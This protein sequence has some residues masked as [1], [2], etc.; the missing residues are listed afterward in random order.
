MKSILRYSLVCALSWSAGSGALAQDG[1]ERY[2]VILDKQIFGEPPAEPTPGQVAAV[3]NDEGPPPTLRLTYLALFQ[4]GS[5]QAGLMD[6]RSSETY[7]LREGE[8]VENIELL[9]INYPSEEVTVRRDGVEFRLVLDDGT[10]SPAAGVSNVPPDR[11]DGRSEEERRQS[12][13]ER[14]RQRMIERRRLFEERRRQ[15]MQG[16]DE[17][18]EPPRRLRGDALMEHL[19]EYNEELIRARGDKGPP[20]PIPLTPEQDARLVNEGVLPP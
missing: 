2:R 4:S 1:F 5:A 18:G 19:R 8:T 7:V 13:L 9:D 10:P 20:L 3:A 11:N 15:A 6:I 14:R 12:Y 16:G 17:E